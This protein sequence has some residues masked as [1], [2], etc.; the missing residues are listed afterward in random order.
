MSVVGIPSVWFTTVVI[1]R[2]CEL[3]QR[4][5]DTKGGLGRTVAMM[6]AGDMLET[7]RRIMNNSEEFLSLL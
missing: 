6:L 4:A 7:Y 2:R 1:Y 3:K 5:E